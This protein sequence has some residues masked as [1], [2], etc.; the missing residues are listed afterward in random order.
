VE[1]TTLHAEFEHGS[2][3]RYRGNLQ[4]IQVCS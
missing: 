2:S 3:G 1:R 4:D